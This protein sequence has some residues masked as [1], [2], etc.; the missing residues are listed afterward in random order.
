VPRDLAALAGVTL[1]TPQPDVP[2]QAVPDKPLGD[3]A[4]RGA[5]GRVPEAVDRV[6][7]LPGP[8]LGDHRAV[9]AGGRVTEQREAG[10]TEGH[11]LD[12]K[13]RQRRAVRSDL[14]AGVLITRQGSVVHPRDGVYPD[15]SDCSRRLRLLYRRS[16]D[17]ARESVR[18]DVGLAGDVPQVGGELGYVGQVSCLPRG[19]LGGG[20]EGRGQRLV[21]REDVERP[22]LEMV[23]ERLDGEVDAE[24]LAVKSGLLLLGVGHLLG[25][26]G[27][28]APET[29]MNCASSAPT[30]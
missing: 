26:V 24:Q 6:E 5:G 13:R 3:S 7:R 2:L 18:D 16:S 14:G 10:S 21:V 22:P 29:A 11:V 4:L 12:H 1:A 19:A 23:P 8:L 17:G 20:P 30:A 9:L 27:H 25:E 28:R 15:Y